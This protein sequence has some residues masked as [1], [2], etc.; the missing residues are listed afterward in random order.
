MAEIH[1]VARVAVRARY[2][3]AFRRDIEARAASAIRHAV[4]SYEPVLEVAP[5]EQK[6]PRRMDDECAATQAQFECDDRNR[7][8]DK[9]PV[10]RALVPAPYLSPRHRHSHAIFP[11]WLRP[12]PARDGH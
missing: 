1:G 2:H 9:G 12:R 4:S 8:D 11:L 10:G 5:D 6:C 7:I 3:N